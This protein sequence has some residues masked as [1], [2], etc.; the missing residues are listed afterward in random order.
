[1]S[2]RDNNDDEDEPQYIEPLTNVQ[3]ERL[4]RAEAV[5]AFNN[6]SKEGDEDDGVFEPKKRERDEE[7]VVADDEEYRRFLIEMGGGEEEVRRVLGMGDQPVTGLEP[8]SEGDGDE[9]DVKERERKVDVDRV[10]ES[11]KRKGIK[12]KADDHFLMK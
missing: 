6:L 12:A 3:S 4:L 11:L 2:N 9:E 7:E 5:S 10:N 1:M 8:L